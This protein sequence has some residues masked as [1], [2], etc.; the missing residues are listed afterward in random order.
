MN[1]VRKICLVATILIIVFHFYSLD[2]YE[3]TSDKNTNHYLG[4]LGMLLLATSFIFGFLEKNED[5]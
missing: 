5:K 1:T 2:Y 3:L 4:I